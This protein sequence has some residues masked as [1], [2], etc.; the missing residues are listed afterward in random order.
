M[1]IV[2]KGMLPKMVGTCETCFTSI[3]LDYRDTNIHSIDGHCDIRCPT[4]GCRS[5]ISLKEKHIFKCKYCGNEN[6]PDKINCLTCGA[7]K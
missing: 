7:P 2:S 6:T 5:W 4:T 1:I 3:K